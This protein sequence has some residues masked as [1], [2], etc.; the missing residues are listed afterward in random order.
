MP[1][2]SNFDEFLTEEVMLEECTINAVKRVVSMQIQDEM[3]AQHLT[4]KSMADKMHTSRSLLDRLLDE[5]DTSL[6][7]S[8]LVGAATALGKSLRVELV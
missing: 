1:K 5:N 4:K 3:K 8:T 7:L 2:G 6:T